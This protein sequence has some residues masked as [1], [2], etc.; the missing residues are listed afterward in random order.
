MTNSTDTLRHDLL[1]GPEAA[2][3]TVSLLR[4]RREHTV[5]LEDEAAIRDA[6]ERIFTELPESLTNHSLYDALIAAGTYVLAEGRVDYLLPVN[7]R[8][9]ALLDDDTIWMSIA[10]IGMLIPMY[11]GAK[12]LEWDEQR[13]DNWDLVVDSTYHVLKELWQE[14]PYHV[15]YGEEL[16]GVI[17]KRLLHKVTV[18]QLSIPSIALLKTS[19]EDNKHPYA[20]LLTFMLQVCREHA[21]VN[22]FGVGET[23]TPEKTVTET[24][25]GT[26]PSGLKR[27]LGKLRSAK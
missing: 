22:V 18:L 9:H 17:Q 4:G 20:R 2:Q 10:A 8:F 11:D 24:E 27:I 26:P 5:V 13:E 12:G 25:T 14:N 23:P 6:L 15:W 7:G 21:D 3:S 16:L 1:A 19:A